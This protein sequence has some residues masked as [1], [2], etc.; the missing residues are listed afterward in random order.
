[1]ST[2]QAL[3]AAPE[4]D[5]VIPIGRRMTLVL[6]GER[7]L[8]GGRGVSDASFE[9]AVANLCRTKWL[10]SRTDVDPMNGRGEKVDASLAPQDAAAE[11]FRVG[12]TDCANQFRVYTRVKSSFMGLGT[13]VAILSRLDEGLLWKGPVKALYES[14]ALPANGRV[15]GKVLGFVRKKISGLESLAWAYAKCTQSGGYVILFQPENGLI[16]DEERQFQILTSAYADPY[17]VRGRYIDAP[18][19][20]GCRSRSPFVL[21]VSKG[22]GMLFE[23]GRTIESAR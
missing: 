19:F 11:I 5:S 21:K 18:Y 23:A 14:G 6:P 1:M 4:F 15:D 10:F 16:Q 20:L 17:E 9:Q 13:P 8:F 12:G 2:R 22:Q 7:S 3:I